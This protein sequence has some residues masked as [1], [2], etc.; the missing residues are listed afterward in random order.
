MTLVIP[1]SEPMWL[2]YALAVTISPIPMQVPIS[3]NLDLFYSALM[4]NDLVSLPC[5]LTHQLQEFLVYFKPGRHQRYLAEFARV[6]EHPLESQPF[7]D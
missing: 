7:G 5:Y 4:N 6:H 3:P 2:F 1:Q